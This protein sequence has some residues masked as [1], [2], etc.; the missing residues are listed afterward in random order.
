MG[1]E[2]VTNIAALLAVLDALVVLQQGDTH[3]LLNRILKPARIEPG[4][5]A[6]REDVQ[7]L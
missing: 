4:L 2:V 1:I 5:G 3:A 7:H 6:A